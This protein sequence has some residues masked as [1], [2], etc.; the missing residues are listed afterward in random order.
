MNEKLP[1]YKWF[2]TRD[3]SS[4]AMHDDFIKVTIRNELISYIEE[5]EP[6]NLYG[7]KK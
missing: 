1:D 5:Y 7:I 4:V 2:V 6:Y 3:T